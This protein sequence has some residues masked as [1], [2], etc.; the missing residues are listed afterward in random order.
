MQTPAGDDG[1]HTLLVQ[2]V[3]VFGIRHLDRLVGGPR[4]AGQFHQ[5]DIAIEDKADVGRVLE[6]RLDRN[7]VA[8]SG[9]KLV[10]ANQNLELAGLHVVKAAIIVRQV[11]AMRRSQHPGVQD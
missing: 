11:D 5:R 1:R 6:D 3:A 8:L 10:D 9:G 7:D 4:R 2:D